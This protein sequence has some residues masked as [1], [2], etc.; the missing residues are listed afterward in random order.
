MIG[1]F[2]RQLEAMLMEVL[3]EE[4]YS[5]ENGK[6]LIL[7]A[8]SSLGTITITSESGKLETNAVGVGGDFF[9][10]IPTGW[11]QEPILLARI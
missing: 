7:D 9:T 4:A 6:R 1:S 8:Y 10:S 3:P 5:G 2:E 11:C